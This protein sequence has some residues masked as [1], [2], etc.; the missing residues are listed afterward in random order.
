M[1]KTIEKIAGDT[2]G[3]SFEFAVY[4]IKGRSRAAPSAY[5]QAAL[6]GGELPGVVAIDALMAEAARRGEPKG[7]CWATSPSCPRPIRSA[8]RNICSATCRAASIWERAPISTA[9]SR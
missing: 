6:H 9:I 8:A 2:D 5:L 1:Q 3:V 7:A 4:R